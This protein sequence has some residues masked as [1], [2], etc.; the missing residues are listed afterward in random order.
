MGA[1]TPQWRSGESFGEVGDE[2]RTTEGLAVEEQSHD[3]STCSPSFAG[4]GSIG[5]HGFAGEQ[6]APVAK[7]RTNGA[8][9][10]QETAMTGSSVIGTVSLT[11][12]EP[13]TGLC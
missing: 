1:W 10:W 4:I 11:L 12:S 8:L 13:A 3:F 7:K 5:T 6:E 9:Q 2:S